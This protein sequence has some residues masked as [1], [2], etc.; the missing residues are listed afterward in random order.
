MDA[1]PGSMVQDRETGSSNEL[2]SIACRLV[3]GIVLFTPAI[4]FDPGNRVGTMSRNI[5]AKALKKIA[6]LSSGSSTTAFDR[7]DLD[8]LCRACHGGAKH[9]ESANGGHG[10]KASGSL[11]R[12]PMVSVL[13]PFLGRQELHA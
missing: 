12:I 13:H 7:S 11:G 1:P 3:R 5:R 9:R 8:R 10:I 2:Q 6:S 4:A